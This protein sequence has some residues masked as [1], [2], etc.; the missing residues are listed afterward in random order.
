MKK[1]SLIL[2]ISF[3]VFSLKA[4]L[5][6]VVQGKVKNSKEQTVRLISILTNEM[7]QECLIGDDGTYKFEYILSKPDFYK[8]MF[9][10]YSEIFIIPNPGQKLT[11]NVDINNINNPEITGSEE[12]SKIYSQFAFREKSDKE[13]VEYTK[14]NQT[15][16]LNNIRKMIK[17]NPNS[18]SCMFFIHELEFDKDYEYYKILADGLESYKDN[19]FVADFRKQ[20]LSIKASDVGSEAIEIDLNDING[21]SVKLSSLNGKFVLVDFWAS[22]CSPCRAESPQMVKMYDKY[23]EKGFEIYSVSLD[24]DKTAWKNAIDKD[25]LGRWTHVSDLKG[26]QSEAGRS[27][28]VTSIPFTVLID[29]QGKVIAKG[30]RGA[31]LEKKLEELIK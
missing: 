21:K 20:V 7:V 4:Q 11:V 10:Q 26:W 17:E 5:T 28:N 24:Q 23:H 18:L 27:Y 31:E 6:T 3:A 8:I 9:D 13:L 1:I 12:T 16:K 30:L 29:P 15:E 2:I 19:G 14:K 22:W 25:K